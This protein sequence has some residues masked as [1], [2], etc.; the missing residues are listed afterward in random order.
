MRR[1]PL[2]T[3]RL[4]S[5][6]QFE[7]RFSWRAT[8]G[9]PTIALTLAQQMPD[10]DGELAGGCDGGD[11]LTAAGAHALKEGAQRARTRAAA[12]PPR[13]ACRGHGRVPAW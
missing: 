2:P 4:M 13:S 10:Q 6:F 7:V 3:R 11:V 5:G 8:P 9:A 12:T 1:S